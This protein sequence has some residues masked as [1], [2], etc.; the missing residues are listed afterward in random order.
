VDNRDSVRRRASRY[1]RMALCLLAA[2]VALALPGGAGAEGSRDIWSLGEN[3]YRASLEWRSSVYGPQTFNLKR[4]TLLEV[5][6][7]QGEYLLVG[8]TAIG[9]SGT[10]NNGD[11]R[12][13]NPGVVTGPIGNKLFPQLSAPDPNQLG[14]FGNGFSCVA[15]RQVAANATRGRIATRAQELA[16]PNTEDNDIPAGYRPC[17]YRAPA[18]GI[19]SVVF[20]GPRGDNSD[21]ETSPRGLIEWDSSD[22]YDAGPLQDTSI[23]AWDV[24]VRRDLNAPTE[25]LGRLFT[26]YFT[27]FTGD[28]GR[29]IV[30]TVFVV[31][32]DG[33]VYKVDF[34][35]D[36]FGFLFY[37]NQKGFEDTNGNPLYRNVLAV[38]TLPFEQQ[39]Q[40]YELQGGVGLLAPEYP[41]L[42]NPPAPET[43][44]ALGIPLAPRQARVGLL[45]FVGSLTGE[46]ALQGVGGTF[47]I[48]SDQPGI[49]TI[50]ISQDGENFDPT[51]EANR[52]LRGSIEGAGE[53]EVFWDGLNNAGE[54]F[55][56]GSAYVAR[57]QVQGGEIHFPF[58]D[59]ENNRN[60]GPQ[61]TLINP[62]D[63][64]GDG[65]G[66]CPPFNGGC[67][68]AFYDD[69]GYRTAD[70]IL[71]GSAVNGPLC[72]NNAGS[73]PSPLVSDPQ[74]GFDTATNQRRFG[75]PSGGNPQRV[76]LASGG[77]GDKKG[78]DL[79]SYYPSEIVTTTLRVV[80]PTAVE[81]TRFAASREGGRTV[82]RWATSGERD[83]W[84]FHLYRAA[85]GLRE[86]AVRLTEQ[87]IPARGVGG[88][89]AS[90][91]WV[92]ESANGPYRYWL[93]E[94]GLDGAR[95]EYGPTTPVAEAG[96]PA[97]RW[98][99]LVVR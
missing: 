16:G 82:V 74:R 44:R 46:T 49:Y 84:G 14:V 31:T 75:F 78:L 88:G 43:L 1:A 81:L 39:N 19:Y 13:F 56:A 57:M 20:L 98:L 66:D 6:V 17:T 45:S 90:Y 60:G 41:I 68:G 12:I 70:G 27:G 77:F 55:A 5:F 35:T 18:S 59:V 26:H 50:I 93:E 58:F 34:D 24:T 99:P 61:I 37:A 71:V 72:P 96:E 64:D 10:P 36:P 65:V 42:F 53:A 52:V 69:R 25:Q 32:R 29:P 76:C 7:E 28:T 47:R 23:T 62:P 21:S 4:R 67:R 73:P 92:D 3:G 9:V 86:E 97:T 15:Q 54:P 89:G 51:D 33:F 95:R 30:S 2:G 94:I 87:L 80:A 85:S 91:E 8:S 83:S 48:G 11:I 63:R 22:P 38:P 79:W 40:L